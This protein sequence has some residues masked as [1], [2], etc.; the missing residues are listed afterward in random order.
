MSHARPDGEHPVEASGRSPT[1]LRA[2]GVTLIGA[3]APGS[4]LLVAGRRRLGA[5]VLAIFAILIGGTGYLLVVRYDDIL[6]LVLQPRWLTWI[7]VVCVSIGLAWV[8]TVLASHMMLRPP[9]CR[10]FNVS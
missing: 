5:A 10:D 4:A 3:L 6:R 2:L 8:G 7:I 1:L 9:P